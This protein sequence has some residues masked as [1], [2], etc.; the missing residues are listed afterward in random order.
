MTPRPSQPATPLPDR[1]R[2]FTLL[3]VML[4]VALSVLVVGAVLALH[5]YARSVRQDV[6]ADVETVSDI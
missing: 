1:R 4:A 5:S 2:G 6:L 3:E